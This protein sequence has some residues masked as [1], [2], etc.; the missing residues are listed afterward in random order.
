MNVSYNAD[1]EP[2]AGVEGITRIAGIH[3]EGV[4]MEGGTV[5]KAVGL[6]EKPIDG[7]SLVDFSGTCKKGM[8]IRNAVKV[9][10][11]EM[12][13]TEFEG[14]KIAV[15]NVEG[16]GLEGAADAGAGKK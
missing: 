2:L 11:R 8:V 15:E 14:P 9:E 4:K 5:L 13:V 12:N 6:K 1:P 16:K 10:L 7:L 3:V